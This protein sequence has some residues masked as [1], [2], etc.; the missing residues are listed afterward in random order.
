MPESDW[1]RQQ[2]DNI[3]CTAKV[4]RCRARIGNLRLAAPMQGAHTAPQARIEAMQAAALHRVSAGTAV[5]K[6]EVAGMKR[7]VTGLRTSI[8][9]WCIPPPRAQ[10]HAGR[11]RITYSL[12]LPPETEIGVMPNVCPHEKRQE[13]SM[14]AA[15]NFADH[16]PA[17][18]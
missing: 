13:T 2:R 14:T 15:V 6:C 9:N 18:P 11:F 5:I 8:M 3:G 4:Q 10:G 16:P 17:R 7:Q 12:G 1:L